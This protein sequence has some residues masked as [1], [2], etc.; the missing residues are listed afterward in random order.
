MGNEHD[1]LQDWK[2][3]L[4]ANNTSES[5]SKYLT[6]AQRFEEWLDTEPDLD[7]LTEFEADLRDGDTLAELKDESGEFGAW[8]RA[9]PPTDGYSYTTRITGLSAA[10]S[11]LDFRYGIEFNS[12]QRHQVQNIVRGE[13]PAFDPEI[14]SPQQVSAVISDTADCRADSCHAMTLLGYD[15]IMRGIEVCRVRF[16]DIDFD[17]GTVY[18]RAAKGSKSCHVSLHDRTLEVLADYRELVLDRFDN[19]EYL[20]YTFYQHWWNKPWHP[21]SWGRHFRR[22]H[23][24]AGFHSFAR[25]SAITNRLN[26]GESLSAV[27]RRARHQNVGMTHKYSQL[28]DGNADPLPELR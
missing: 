1:D 25:H 2:E 21:R 24:D 23:W 27:S 28:V 16:D 19:P 4:G 26:N 15:A 6:W 3:M 8:R 22:D 9:Q 5:V 7:T 20:F 18:V 14:A 11:W 13:P 12:R 10:K 17:R